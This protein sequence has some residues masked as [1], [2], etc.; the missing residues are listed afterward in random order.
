MLGTS[1]LFEVERPRLTAMGSCCGC[2]APLPACTSS[3]T[4]VS[5]SLVR[6]AGVE[7]LMALSMKK[8]PCTCGAST[9]MPWLWDGPLGWRDH[10]N[11]FVAVLGLSSSKTTRGRRGIFQDEA[12]GGRTVNSQCSQ[13]G[14]PSFASQ[15]LC[16][17][18]FHRFFSR[19]STSHSL[20]YSSLSVLRVVLDTVEI[21]ISPGFFQVETVSEIETPT[22]F[23]SLVRE[24]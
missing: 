12:V 14:L 19:H 8:S 17:E 10:A 2:P 4:D 18:P 3:S 5:L 15:K 24:L 11:A 13:C 16:C 20:L 23:T 9:P 22:S 6:L 1:G 7:S 21:P